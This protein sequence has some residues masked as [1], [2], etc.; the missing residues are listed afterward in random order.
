MTSI[1]CVQ[2]GLINF[3]TAVQCKRCQMPLNEFS[4]IADER[5]YQTS[6]EQTQP[7]NQNQTPFQTFQTPP[8]PPMF[9]GNGFEQPASQAPLSCVKC[10][11]RRGVY[12]Q[13]FKKDYIPP[14]AYLGMFIGVLPM[15]IMIV[16]LKVTHPITA[17]FCNECWSKFRKVGTVEALMALSFLAAIV[18]GVVVMI[19][20]DAG[21]S[22]FF[23][24]PLTLGFIVWG[25]IYKYKHS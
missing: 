23:F 4:A 11:G 25:Q 20:L 9:D 17:P 2:C 10:G 13:D 7:F 5:A 18:I 14:V 6:A 19:L 12:L 24:F 8:P 21:F 16:I 22:A 3:S 15:I 1:K